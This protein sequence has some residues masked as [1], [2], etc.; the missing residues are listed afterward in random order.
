MSTAD[1]MVTHK[2]HYLS[3]EDWRDNYYMYGYWFLVGSSKDA[4]VHAYVWEEDTAIKYAKEHH[5]TVYTGGNHNH[6]TR[7]AS[8][9]E[10]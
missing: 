3:I 2:H 10:V 1:R 7:V 4:T 8:F 9:E 6:L 5:A